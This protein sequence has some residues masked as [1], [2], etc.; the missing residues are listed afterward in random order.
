MNPVLANLPTTIFT[1]M[2]GLARDLGAINLGQG[3]PDDPGPEDVRRKAAE[4]VLDG[5]NQYPPMMGLP[6]LRA[7]VAAHYRH[8][9]DLA[10]DPQT[11]VMVT[12]G[13]TE[14]LAAALIGLIAPGDEV[15]LFAPL[16]DAYLP[17]VRQ[18]G[19]VPRI[20]NLAPPHFQLE[21]EA[22]A[23]VFSDRTKLVVLNNP[24]N[25][26][27][28]VFGRENLSLLARFCT[29]H[30][31]VAVCDEV[32]EHIVFDGAT[33]CPL[34]ALPGMRDRTVKIGSAGKIFGLTGWKVG[35][36]MAA[37]PLLK[38][39]GQAH[40]FLTF[41]TPPCLQTAVAYG[42][43]KDDD[44]FTAMRTRF[45]HSRDRL[46]AGLAARGFTVLPSAGTYFLNIDIA[47]LGFSDDVAFCDALVRRHGVA[48][49]PVSAFYD[50]D[51]VRHI[52]RLCFAKSDATLDAALDRLGDVARTAA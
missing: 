16:Y 25:P 9:Q 3:F 30:D 14:A 41:T 19:G 22:L 17:L 48:A 37:A 12:S 44:Y 23:A 39:V 11:E 42:L 46:S 47:P 36:V 18:A 4:A 8:H 10:L 15:V 27:A 33:H 32:W 2:S 5:D 49:I 38:A 6:S 51:P 52:V 7:A 24:L 13:A 34:M 35:F 20:V 40:Q 31:V 43:A 26:S 29:R 50:A 28:T 21:E 1:V 45:A